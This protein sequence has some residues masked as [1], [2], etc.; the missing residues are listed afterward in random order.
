MLRIRG[1]RHKT[2]VVWR[3]RCLLG[4]ARLRS[5]LRAATVRSFIADEAGGGRF[6]WPFHC[7]AWEG[8]VTVVVVTV[9]VVTVLVVTG[10]VVTVLVF[11]D[12][13][14]T[15]KLISGVEESTK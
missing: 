4:P 14:A 2:E 13:S 7:A 1:G 15:L 8:K 5:E 12:C 6:W 11:C 3:V 9:V 10:L